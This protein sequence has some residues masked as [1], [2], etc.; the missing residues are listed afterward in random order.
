[1]RGGR[2]RRHQGGRRPGLRGRR[3]HHGAHRRRRRR[4]SRRTSPPRHP[5]SS[6]GRHLAATAGRS[7][8]IVRHVG[9]RE[10]RDG[11]PGLDR[12]RGP[13]RRRSPAGRRRRATRCSSPRPGSSAC[14]S[15]FAACPGRSPAL[16]ARRRDAGARPAAATGDPHHRLGARRPTRRLRGVPRR[17]DGQGRGD[18]R[19]E[20]GHDAGRPHDRRGLRAGALVRAAARRGRPDVQPDPRRRV[21]VDERHRRRARLGG[22]RPRLGRA[23]R[24]RARSGVRV[25]RAP[26]GGR[27]RGRD[28]DG[29]GDGARGRE[30]PPGACRGAGGRG[31]P[32]RQ[33]LPQR[34]RPLLGPGRRRA[35]RGGRRLRARPRARCATAG[36][37]VCVGGEG[38]APRRRRRSPRT[39]R[40]AT[41]SSVATSVSARG[42]AR[43]CAATS[44]HG[45]LDENRTTS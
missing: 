21:D 18:A 15:T 17:G 11:A 7:R 6:R 41:S 9:K 37:A 32:P 36:I 35:G 13:A 31:L 1:M 20:P 39:S 38:V 8:A 19:P 34:R 23:A 3:L 43:C 10:R 45:Y 40:G 22:R 5:S 2:P 30:R 26:D 42:G 25:A 16:R 28:E 14:R 4:S 27:R 12:R 24:R 29:D 44:G 33:V